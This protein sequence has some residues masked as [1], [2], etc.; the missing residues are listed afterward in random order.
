MINSQ[1]VQEFKSL[2]LRGTITPT[3]GSYLLWESPRL[4]TMYP[5][6]GMPKGADRAVCHTVN[7]FLT[8]NFK[9]KTIFDPT[10]ADAVANLRLYAGLYGEYAGISGVIQSTE[11]RLSDI[12]TI[13]AYQSN[14]GIGFDAWSSFSNLAQNIYIRFTIIRVSA[15]G[16][17]Q[18]QPVDVS[19]TGALIAS[20]LR[21]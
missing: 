1:P 10:N 14:G 7:G 6:E 4:T 19:F 2:P 18:D 15:I 12:G 9:D 20:D 21:F 11:L 5:M 16:N 8:A 3:I 17:A 13:T